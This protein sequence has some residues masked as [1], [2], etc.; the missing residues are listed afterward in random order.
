MDLLLTR[1]IIDLT[2]ESINQSINQPMDLLSP[3]KLHQ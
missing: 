3:R 1:V 2:K